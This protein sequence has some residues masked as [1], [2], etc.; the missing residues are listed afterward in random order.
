MISNF[1]GIL[2]NL[3]VTAGFVIRKLDL[4]HILYPAGGEYMPV[5]YEIF[6]TA[7]MMYLAGVWTAELGWF[8]GKWSLWWLIAQHVKPGSRGAWL[9]WRFPPILRGI[10]G[11]LIAAVPVSYFGFGY[12]PPISWLFILG[13]ALFG[14]I[15]YAIF[16]HE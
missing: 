14:T 11:V 1:N 6:F 2:L 3:K 10:A 5:V 9:V 15:L 4:I 16:R 7:V 12:Q 8:N 13:G